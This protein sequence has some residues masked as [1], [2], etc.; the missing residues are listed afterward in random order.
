VIHAEWLQPAPDGSACGP[1]LE[2]DQ[3]YLAL[4]EASRGRPEQQ[5][6]D[7]VIPA[8]EPDWDD[9]VKRASALL[10]RSRDL[11]IAHLLTRG[12]VRTQGVVGLRDGLQLVQGLLETFWDTLHPQLEFEGEADPVMRMNALTMFADSDGLVRDLRQAVLLRTPLGS[13]TL[14]D[15][16]RILERAG[17]GGE[18]AVT[19]DQLRMVIRDAIAADPG[20]LAE[21]AES[22]EALER[23][24]ALPAERLG[25]ALAPDLT[26]L[27][28]A[29]APAGRLVDAARAELAGQAQASGGAAGSAEVAG[30]TA[31]VVTGVGEIRSRDDAHRALERV[32]EFLARNEP[33]NPAPL[34]IRRAQRVMTMS[35]V[36]IVRDLIPDAVAQ[37]ENLAGKSE[38]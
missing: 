6:G 11:R 38:S 8:Q 28:K 25:P 37:V 14:R 24:H 20:A 5:Y 34:L 23:I 10:G 7:T 27:K 31:S 19:P 21:V 33:T 32:C 22:V 4:E 17:G 3:D 30:S 26:P 36:E 9:V 18:P 12:L 35:F 29:L 2:Y 15:V 16:E 1:N 13:F